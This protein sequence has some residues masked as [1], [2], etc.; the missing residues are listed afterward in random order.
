MS[1]VKISGLPLAGPLTGACV[2]PL[3]QVGVTSQVILDTLKIFVNSGGTTGAGVFTTLSAS[4]NGLIGAATNE[5]G[6]GTLYVKGSTGVG[7][8]SKSTLA[9]SAAVAA[10][11]SIT[12]GTVKQISFYQGSGTELGDIST[13]TNS[14]IYNS[15]GDL[16]L[17]KA[18][19]IIATVSSTGLTV[20]GILNATG[21]LNA[22]GLVTFN[23]S[24]ITANFANIKNTGGTSTVLVDTSTGV[25]YSA[26]NY[27]SIYGA[28]TN[29]NVG[30]ITNN[31]L[32]ATIDATGTL[33]LGVVPST[34]TVK[35]IEVGSVGN[36]VWTTGTNEIRVSTNTNYNVGYKYTTTAAAAMYVQSVGAHYWNTAASGTAGTAITFTQAMSLDASG[37]LSTTGSHTVGTNVGV[38]TSRQGVYINNDGYSVPSNNGATAN[39]DKFVMWNA[40]SF[41]AAIGIDSGTMWL[42]STG[43]S[44]ALGGFKFYNGNAASPVSVLEISPTGNLGLGITPSAWQATKKAF[45]FGSVGTI[46]QDSVS[47]VEFTS[48]SYT[49]VSAVDTYISSSATAKPVKTYLSNGQL[50]I[51]FSPAGTAGTAITWTTS[52]YLSKGTALTLEGG[53]STAGT[54]IAFPATQLASADA[55]TLDDYEEGTFTPA[56]TFGSGSVTYTT[57][58]GTYTK[59]GRLVTCQLNIVVN[60]I[61]APSGTLQISAL[62]FTST[63]TGKG[64]VPILGTVMAATAATT[65]V[66]QVNPSAATC[67]VYRFAAGAIASPGA[68]IIASSTISATIT[69][70]TA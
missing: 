39:G 40:G 52:L 29:T 51:Q 15:V 10:W 48:N 8:V 25:N 59:V 19:N 4:V 13:D 34:W 64:A 18:G 7:I 41:K 12:T 1:D 61:A 6:G 33:G 31:I 50:G 3:V 47:S 23:N 28:V 60:T 56:L 17:A 43:N 45:Q 37:N 24:A 9:G 32:R 35:A 62:P 26:G 36:A 42:Q 20:T 16:K 2:F 5:F 14:T 21:A 44:T 70:E 30:F 27:A 53:T 67:S 55:N 46:S 22:T 63:A 38:A 68:D 11:N 49:N 69:Y 66:G 65:L 54:G 58:T 57:Q